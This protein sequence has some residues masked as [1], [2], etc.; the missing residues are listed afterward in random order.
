MRSYGGVCLLVVVTFVSLARVHA[1]VSLP[2]I[3]SSHMVLQ[4]DITMPWIWGTGEAGKLVIVTLTGPNYTWKKQLATRADGSF[5]VALG[6]QPQRAG[7][8]FTISVEDEDNTIMLE[9]IAFGDV[10]LCSGQSNMELTS[11]PYQHTTEVECF[12]DAMDIVDEQI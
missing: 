8:N 2:S 5:E 10:I 6:D 4:R 11:E 12:I 1:F 7:T 9:N 3:I